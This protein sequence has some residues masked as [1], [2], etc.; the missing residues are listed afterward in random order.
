MVGS[1]AA[2]TRRSASR[3]FSMPKAVCMRPRRK[4]G[5]GVSPALD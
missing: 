1:S 3:V 5:T 4:S 2:T